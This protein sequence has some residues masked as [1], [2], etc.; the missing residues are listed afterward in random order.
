MG[1]YGG[2]LQASMSPSDAGNI[3]DIDNDDS[4]NFRDFAPFADS[5]QSQQVLLPE[6]LDRD[7]AV[8]YND[9][10]IFAENWLYGEPGN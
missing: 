8:D 6:D 1:D 7:G 5:W 9:L 4:V 3:A 2:T 10:A